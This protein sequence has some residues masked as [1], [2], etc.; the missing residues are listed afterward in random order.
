MRV[1]PMM[2]F[3]G[4]RS[5]WLML[6]RKALLAWLAGDRLLARPPQFPH[7]VIQHHSFHHLPVDFNDLTKQLHVDECAVF[8]ASAG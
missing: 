2:A 6:A 1:K 3:S 7:V 5:S 4:V 8:A